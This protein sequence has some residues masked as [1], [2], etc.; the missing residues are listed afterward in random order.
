MGRVPPGPGVACDPG[1]EAYPAAD[2]A[3]Q[4][5]FLAAAV[6][7]RPP[8]SLP[9]G[10]FAEGDCHARIPAAA[11]ESRIRLSPESHSSALRKVPVPA[12]DC[13]W[14]DRERRCAGRNSGKPA[15]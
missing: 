1:T 11:R 3:L 10:D 4:V 15:P 9:G 5:F 2:R 7:K 14:T 6:F 12:R 13:A 8:A